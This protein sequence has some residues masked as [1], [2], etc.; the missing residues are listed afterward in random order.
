MSL[1][2]IQ[3]IEDYMKAHV[4]KFEKENNVKIVCQKKEV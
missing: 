4:E 1:L 2:D 3:E